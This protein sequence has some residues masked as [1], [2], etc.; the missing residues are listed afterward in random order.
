M[1][2]K[3]GMLNANFRLSVLAILMMGLLSATALGYAVVQNRIERQLRTAIADRDLL[4]REV[5]HRVKN[6]LQMTT[7]LLMSGAA[8]VKDTDARA[9]LYGTTKRIEALGTVHRLLISSRMPSEVDAKEFLQDLCDNIV[10]GHREPGKDI[11]L[12]IAVDPGAVHIDFAVALGLL[13]NELVTNALKHGFEGKDGGTISVRYRQK[14]ERG[15]SLT[16]ADDGIGAAGLFEE[17]AI[18]GAGSR[19]VRGLVRQL[20]AEMTVGARQGTV[21]VINVPASAMEGAEYE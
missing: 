20:G 11:A 8:R 10:S 15:V 4:L 14:P 16:V 19:I 18:A 6:N 13:T 2:T 1:F 7:A 17:E 21:V 5:Y 9:L 12:D 3:A